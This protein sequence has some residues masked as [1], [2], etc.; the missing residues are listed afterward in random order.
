LR[1]ARRKEKICKIQKFI[2]VHN[3]QQNKAN[4]AKNQAEIKS[5]IKPCKSD[6][7]YA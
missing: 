2:I 7:K 4:Q 5:L 6:K 3:H 1:N